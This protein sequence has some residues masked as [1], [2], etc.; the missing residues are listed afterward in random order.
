MAN[1]PNKETWRNS[2][3]GKRH[4]LKY[5]PRGDLETEIVRSGGTVQLTPE[6]REI[7]MDKAANDKLCIFR[8]GSL[9]P[10]RILD[11]ELQAEFAAN[12]NNLGDS[13][14]TKLFTAHWKTF[15]AR[16]D[17]IDNMLT[18]ERLLD[19]AED[20]E[21]GATVRQHTAIKARLEEVTGGYVQESDHRIV[22][23]GIKSETKAWATF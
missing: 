17:E 4:V 3:K 5:G 10:V 22:N 19:I 15:D 16:L 21:S 13:E 20:P 6:E 23:T 8:N 1:N 14:A 9:T 18:L 2:T 11:D 7:N 12:P